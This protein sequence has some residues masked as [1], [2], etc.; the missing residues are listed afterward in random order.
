MDI[1]AIQAELHSLLVNVYGG[2][3]VGIVI[4]S[5]LFGIITV[6]AYTHFQNFPR[7][8]VYVKAMIIFLW[9]VTEHLGCPSQ[10]LVLTFAQPQG[11][12]KPLNSTKAMYWYL[13]SNF[14][15]SFLLIRAIWEGTTYQTISTV[16]SFTTQ[17]FFA[18]RVYQLSR[19]IL[20]GAFLELLVLGQCTLGALTAFK[21]YYYGN[22][23]DIAAHEKS[24]VL[25]WL[26]AEAISDTAIALS[27]VLLLRRQK[28]GFDKTDTMINSLM[29]YSIST[30]T[31]TSFVAIVTCVIF[32]IWEFHFLVLALAPSLGALYTVTLLANLHSRTKIRARYFAS[33]TPIP[34]TTVATGGSNSAA[35]KRAHTL[36]AGS[37]GPMRKDPSFAGFSKL[38]NIDGTRSAES[39]LAAVNPAF[40]R[41]PP[42]RPRARAQ[43]S[44]YPPTARPG[45]PARSASA[46]AHVQAHVA[47]GNARV[48]LGA[49]P[50][51][52]PAVNQGLHIHVQS[53]RTVMTDASYS[54]PTS[55]TP[56]QP[57][58]QPIPFPGRA[59]VRST[60]EPRYP[61]GYPYGRARADS[62]ALS[63][64]ESLGS[65]ASDLSTSYDFIVHAI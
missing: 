18:Y 33:V 37:G 9:Y 42:A 36:S 39:R 8:S 45:A 4:T 38:D 3:L 60:S 41:I 54:P 55:A 26:A 49:V 28:K 30:G 63:L 12:Y 11:S 10:D 40:T 27:L 47:R 2:A 64:D 22:F 59:A 46:Y 35:S 17:S 44:P 23:S 5:M 53:T 1:Q 51:S 25:A 56:L 48:G 62:Q 34:M 29:I 7:D 65:P 16:A 50:S 61:Y 15:N 31:V 57:S 32:A 20:L 52:R 6:Q 24:L 13:V 21:A 19:N 58:A 14:G 43:S